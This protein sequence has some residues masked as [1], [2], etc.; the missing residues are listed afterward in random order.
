MNHKDRNAKDGK[1]LVGIP[2]L[3]RPERFKPLAGF[4]ELRFWRYLQG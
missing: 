1:I 2:Q 4:D 3:S